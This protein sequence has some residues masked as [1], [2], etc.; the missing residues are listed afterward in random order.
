M[1]HVDVAFVLVG[2]LVIAVR[3]R[4]EFPCTRR[5]HGCMPLRDTVYISLSVV[6]QEAL[7]D[8]LP[9]KNGRQRRG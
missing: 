8:C 3:L 4:P 5:G 7:V 2:Q 6:L 9:L 1:C